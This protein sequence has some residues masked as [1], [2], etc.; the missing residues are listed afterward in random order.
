MNHQQLFQIKYSLW[1]K[2]E[3]VLVFFNDVFKPNNVIKLRALDRTFQE[4]DV[5]L[6]ECVFQLLV[7]FFQCQQPFHMGNYEK[8]EISICRHRELL[9]K[10]TECWDKETLEIF[11]N[12]LDI[13][14]W[15][16]IVNINK[17]NV[18]TAVLR[19]TNDVNEA[20][21]AERLFDDQVTDRLCYVLK[22][23]HLL[24]T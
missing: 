13:A 24:W 10:H 20:L 3:G 12:L 9:A 8:G 4:T 18:F 21:K 5:L 1:K 2:W 16:Q 22:H 6:E 11:K 17:S 19:S 7:D 14:E 15:Y 23:R